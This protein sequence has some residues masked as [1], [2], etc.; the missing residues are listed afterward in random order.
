MNVSFD[1]NSNNISRVMTSVS[2]NS[3]ISNSNSNQVTQTPTEFA[4]IKTLP[5]EV[6]AKIIAY[7]GASSNHASV[8]K[9]FSEAHRLAAFSSADFCKATD[10]TVK[11]DSLWEAIQNGTRFDISLKTPEGIDA[12]H[13]LLG[14]RAY[15]PTFAGLINRS[16]EG[17]EI[18]QLRPLDTTTTIK[19]EEFF[20]T[21]ELALYSGNEEI[22][23]LHLK[24][25]KEFE[26]F[27]ST[28]NETLLY[29]S[30]RNKFVNQLKKSMAKAFILGYLRGDRDTSRLVMPFV[31]ELAPIEVEFSQVV[32]WIQLNA[33]ALSPDSTMGF[34]AMLNEELN[35]DFKV[36]ACDKEAIALYDLVEKC[37]HNDSVSVAFVNK[38]LTSIIAFPHIGI[39]KK[40]KLATYAGNKQIISYYSRYPDVYKK[41]ICKALLFAHQRNCTKGIEIWS[42][43]LKDIDAYKLFFAIMESKNKGF[44]Q[45]IYNRLKR[46]FPNIPQNILWA[47]IN[48]GI[49]AVIFA[50]VCP[51]ETE[52]EG[53][54]SV[55][56]VQS[57]FGGAVNGA[58]FALTRYAINTIGNLCKEFAFTKNWLSVKNALEGKPFD[59]DS[60]FVFFLRPAV[61]QIAVQLLTHHSLSYNTSFHAG[62]MAEY[63]L[64]INKLI[65]S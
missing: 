53:W 15:D 18:P 13:S 32:K 45:S 26:T 37:S 36:S 52:I 17:F 9:N 35:F 28:E 60:N 58:V 43:H 63:L 7:S 41:V 62:M 12:V 10:S 6:L 34:L 1:N 19:L 22:I 3:N 27:L 8:N 44:F 4:P 49:C 33:S 14:N 39:A 59:D 54:F 46:D 23:Q 48:T 42:R 61:R 30:L 2:E 29:P 5:T 11:R 47:S 50:L 55:E 21:L 20:K 25:L 24:E 16:F 31:K 51:E 57:Q 40:L 38:L 64:M 65:W 56:K